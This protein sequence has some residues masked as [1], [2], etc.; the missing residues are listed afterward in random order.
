MEKKLKLVVLGDSCVG[1]TSLLFA[2]TENRLLENYTA[3][4]LENWAVS[5]TI[6]QKQYTVNLFDTAGQVCP[7]IC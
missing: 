5:V 7:S 4:V 3:T 2:Y 1:K 6:D